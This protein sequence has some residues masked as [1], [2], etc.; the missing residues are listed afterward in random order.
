MAQMGAAQPAYQDDAHP[1]RALV[2]GAGGAVGR[3]TT[4]ELRRLGVTVTGVG[5]TPPDGGIRMDVSQPEGLAKLRDAAAAHDVVVNASGVEDPRLAQAVGDAV[6]VEISA[7]SSYLEQLATLSTGIVMGAGLAPGLSTVLAA[8]LKAEP[9]DEIDV[10]IMLGGGETHGNAAIAWT[11]GLIGKPLHDPPEARRM[12]NFRDRIRI[13][14]RSGERI[15]LRADFPDHTLVGKPRKVVIRSWLA[16]DNRLATEALALAGR[17]P[18]LRWL[19]Q[20]APHIGSTRWSLVVNNRRTGQVLT[21]RGDGQ[22]TTTGVLTARAAAAAVR[23]QTRSPVTTADL[24][25]I[26]DLR[27]FDVRVDN[28]GSSYL[29]VG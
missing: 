23:R 25:T 16:V 29:S 20:H 21:A 3:A 19:V 27:D 6:F 18:L 26:D 5:R 10:A 7:T 17:V 1:V 2:L 11:A 14:D 12:L 15:Y 9:G 13:S 4:A 8:N 24:L 22:S 28:C